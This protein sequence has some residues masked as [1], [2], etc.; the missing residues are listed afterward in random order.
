MQG[1]Y[2]QTM[3]LWCK[4]LI[5]FTFLPDSQRAKSGSKTPCGPGPTPMSY[6]K[7]YPQRMWATFAAAA[8]RIC[9]GLRD[10]RERGSA[11]AGAILALKCTVTML[12]SHK[13]MLSNL[14]WVL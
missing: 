11:A 12:R 3:V 6:Q 1:R 2:L 9:L 5:E 4:W 14:E 7:T 8:P 10:A 13:D